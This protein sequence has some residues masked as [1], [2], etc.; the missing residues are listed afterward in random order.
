MR[1]GV[2]RAQGADHLPVGIA[3]RKAGIGVETQ[4]DA[5][6]MISKRGLGRVLDV[7]RTTREERGR[8]ET[9][10]YRGHPECRER[11]AEPDHAHKVLLIVD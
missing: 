2:E 7:Q 1:P 8:A 3:Q 10:V 6:R 9:G 5:S 4:L 11:L